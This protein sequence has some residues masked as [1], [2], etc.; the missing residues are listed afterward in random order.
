MVTSGVLIEAALRKQHKHMYLCFPFPLSETSCE[1]KSSKNKL[2]IG[3]MACTFSFVK[4]TASHICSH[5]NWFKLIM[6]CSY[7]V[8]LRRDTISTYCSELNF[9]W[10]LLLE[11]QY[12]SDR[13]C[14]K[15]IHTLN[16]LL[17]V[18]SE[19]GKVKVDFFKCNT[20][21]LWKEK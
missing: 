9:L 12:Q 20:L 15:F 16:S 4:F 6:W 17:P 13:K 3:I 10:F 1:P 7:S 18:C 5:Y 14:I 21:K 2:S 11:L 8:H 19:V